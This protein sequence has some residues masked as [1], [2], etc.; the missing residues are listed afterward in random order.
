MHTDTDIKSLFGGIA[1]IKP[2]SLPQQAS[3]ALGSLQQNATIV[4]EPAIAP[5]R[6]TG[7]VQLFI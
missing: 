4:L 7:A 1:R 2:L 5:E 3:P 6:A